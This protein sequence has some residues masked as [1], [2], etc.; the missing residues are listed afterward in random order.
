M[1][2]VGSSSYNGLQV[3]ANKRFHRGLTILVNCTWSKSIDE[4]S[5]DGSA[6]SNPYNIRN[7]RAVPDFDIPHKFV[8]SFVWQIPDPV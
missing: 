7:D 5:N 2:S 1:L 8:G 3:S 4:G 6:P